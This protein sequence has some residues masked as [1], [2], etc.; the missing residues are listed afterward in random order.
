[1]PLIDE[2]V[3]ATQQLAQQNN[4]RLLIEAHENLGTLTVGPDA[5]TANPAQPVE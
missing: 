1:M 4:N 3:G 2:V 5:A